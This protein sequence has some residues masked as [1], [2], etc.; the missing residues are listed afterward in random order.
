MSKKKGLK[1]AT[2]KFRNLKSIFIYLMGLHGGY[3]IKGC[4][5][6]KHYVDFVKGK[7]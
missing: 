3:L 2:L 5:L 1:F 6:F 4:N 7:D